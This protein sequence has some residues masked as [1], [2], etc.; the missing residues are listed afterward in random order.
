MRSI[1][2]LENK[3]AAARRQDACLAGGRCGSG[4]EDGAGWAGVAKSLA[5]PLTSVIADYGAAAETPGRRRDV[6]GTPCWG[7]TDTKGMFWI[8]I[9]TAWRVSGDGLSPTSPCCR[10]ASREEPCHPA[11]PSLTLRHLRH[12]GSP[13]VT[14]VIQHPLTSPLRHS[15]NPNHPA[16]PCDALRRVTSSCVGPS[17]VTHTCTPS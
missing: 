7:D 9:G 5:S 8:C 15:F 12:P 13:C 2:R 1:R 3:Y 11:S 4:R 17:T 14:N 10:G 16:P 6:R